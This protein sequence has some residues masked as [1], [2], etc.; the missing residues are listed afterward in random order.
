MVK[1][2]I[3][4]GEAKKL[5]N[6][7]PGKTKKG[8]RE[9]I[10]NKTVINYKNE[11]YQCFQASVKLNG[12][13]KESSFLFLLSPRQETYREIKEVLNCFAVYLGDDE[14]MIYV[15]LNGK[16]NK[17]RYSLNEKSDQFIITLPEISVRET[18]ELSHV[19]FH[20]FQEEK[21]RGRLAKLKLLKKGGLGQWISIKD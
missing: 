12:S 17:Q 5:V 6:F 7:W 19:L 4:V 18:N 13:E 1:V 16:K 14:E 2:V 10:Y 9:I 3:L 15:S 21:E 11:K 20:N 8:G